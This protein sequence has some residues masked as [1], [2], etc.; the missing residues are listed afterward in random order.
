MRAGGSSRRTETICPRGTMMS[1]TCRS[2]TSSTPSS[3]VSA[4][5]SSS[6]RSLASRSMRDEVLA[7][8]RLAREICVILF[9]QRPVAFRSF[10][11]LLSSS[12]SGD[13]DWR[14]RAPE[15]G[16][17]AALHAARIGVALVVVAD[18]MQ[19]AVHDEMRPMRAQLLPCSRASARSTCGQ[20]TRSPSGCAGAIAA[21]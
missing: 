13:R 9:S 12:S 21:R 4:S 14:S 6:P 17:L 2:A 3:M 16:D 11:M 18:Q 19:R 15:H 20:I 1:R 8:L 10:D 5:S 7:I